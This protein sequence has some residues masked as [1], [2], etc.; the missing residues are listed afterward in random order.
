MN[1]SPFPKT[2]N[3]RRVGL[4]AI[5]LA[6]SLAACGT[7]SQEPAAAGSSGAKDNGKYQAVLDK[8]DGLTGSARRDELVKLAKSEGGVLSLY[9]SM[10]PEGGGKAL[11]EAFKNDTGV[12][13]SSYRAND[14]DVRTRLLQEAQAKKIG[15][16]FLEGGGQN[17]EII[18]RQGLLFDYDAP[19]MSKLLPEANQKGWVA[20]R[21]NPFVVEW[22]TDLVKNGDEPQHYEDLGDPKFKG[23]VAIDSEDFI[24]FKSVYD[25][26]TGKEG[27]S[28][29]QADAAWKA[30]AK[31]TSFTSGHTKT[32]DF[33]AAG[34][35]AIYVQFMDSV[36]TSIKAG[37]PIQWT[38]ALEPIFALPNGGGPLKDATHP[39]TALLF[40]E[41]LLSDGQKIL[42]D[43]S[44]VPVDKS[45][46]DSSLEKKMQGVDIGKYVD[47][48]Q[49]WDSKFQ[50]LQQASGGK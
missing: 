32:Q 22:N 43:S 49:E 17:S 9:T 41:W 20:D 12:T 25:Y 40:E 39:A 1:N 50:E 35:Y 28:K 15:A 8:I 14:D 19:Q 36:L 3:R 18:A 13:V 21:L 48:M 5:A 16:D 4:M 30:I 46:V 10:N 47:N 37:A 23:Q 29:K 27:M 45:L 2:G 34:Q 44:L 26:M 7:P 38:P 31:N 33:V 6:M 11:Y 42:K 24:W